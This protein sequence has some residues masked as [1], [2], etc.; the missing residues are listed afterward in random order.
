VAEDQ[1]LAHHSGADAPVL[2]VVDVGAADAD[3]ADL[4][5]DLAWSRLGHA[6]VIDAQVADAVQD[7]RA[8]PHRAAPP[9]QVWPDRS[10]SLTVGR[11]RH[12]DLKAV[13]VAEGR[14]RLLVAVE[15]DAKGE[16][17]LGVDRAGDQQVAEAGRRWNQL[18][19]AVVA[20]GSWDPSHSQLHVALSQR[21]R[22][23]LRSQGACAE[24]CA[25]LL[26][27]DG[28]P[29]ATEFTD[30][31]TPSPPGSCARSTR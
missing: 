17:G 12:L 7:N 19:K 22:D 10:R 3:G 24:L 28:Q 23:L 2:V 16:H 27:A 20:I 31:C 30:R 15:R 25:N 13:A 14:D 21:E 26:D 8:V 18:T 9:F 4:H 6:D 5:Q 1:R 11:R 29:V